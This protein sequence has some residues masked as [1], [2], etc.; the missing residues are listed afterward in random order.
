M[1]KTFTLFLTLTFLIGGLAY[2]QNYSGLAKN[3]RLS[4]EKT[5]SP[6]KGT[7]AIDSATTITCSSFWINRMQ[8]LEFAM[9]YA[10][11]GSEFM[12]GLRMV[13]PAG[14][15]PNVAG[16][17]NPL[18]TPNGCRDAHLDLTLNGQSLL[19]GVDTNSMCGAYR[20]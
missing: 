18:T 20:G 6:T 8:T 7:K 3:N 4:A 19:W 15:V 16:T 1:K 12:D 5:I 2:A 14:M 10:Q 9:T 13:F 17:S 11:A